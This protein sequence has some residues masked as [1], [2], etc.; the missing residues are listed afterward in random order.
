MKNVEKVKKESWYI[1]RNKGIL[2]V[3]CRTEQN[4]LILLHRFIMDV[5]EFMVVDHIDR[6]TLDNRRENL[7][8]CTKAQNCRNRKTP[9]NS[10]TRVSGVSFYKARD[11]YRAYISC[12]KKQIHLGFF[13]NIED[14]IEERRKAELLYFKE[15]ADNQPK[16]NHIE[17]RII[18]NETYESRNL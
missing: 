8:I 6:N 4:E 18:L 1:H 11:S 10:K 14:A 7:R 5:T 9:N 15:F 2:Y 17:Q 13:K 16:E 3:R 12:N